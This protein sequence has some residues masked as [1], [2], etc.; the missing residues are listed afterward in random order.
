MKFIVIHAI[1]KY[2]LLTKESHAMQYKKTI[3]WDIFQA[4]NP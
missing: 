3:S 2:N 1:L 4:Q